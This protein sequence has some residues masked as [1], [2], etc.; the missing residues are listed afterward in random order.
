MDAINSKS[1][2]AAEL[3]EIVTDQLEAL[4]TLMEGNDDSYNPLIDTIIRTQKAAIRMVKA[5]A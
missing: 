2:P 1:Q 3:M 4:K 5:A